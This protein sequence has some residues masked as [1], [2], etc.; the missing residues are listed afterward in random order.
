MVMARLLVLVSMTLTL[1]GCLVLP[2]TYIKASAPGAEQ[3]SSACAGAGP[4]KN[5]AVL[6]G[7]EGIMISIQPSLPRSTIFIDVKLYIPPTSPVSVRF[8]SGVFLLTDEVTKVVHEYRA[9][10][11]WGPLA[12]GGPRINIQAPLS[13]TP[14][15]PHRGLPNP[16]RWFG[17]TIDYNPYSISFSFKDVQSK[18]FRLRIPPLIVGAQTFEFPDVDIREVREWIVGTLNC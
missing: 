9:E 12:A 5:M 17:K 18:Q 6:N 1:A 3:H 13:D 16:P 2:D 4:Y 10:H 8:A 11:V 7:P 14:R 15:I